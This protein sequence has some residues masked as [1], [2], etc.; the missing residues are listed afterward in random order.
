VSGATAER[1]R[2]ARRLDPDELAALEDE[3]DH[4]LT[5]LEDLEREHD[6]GDLDDA[7]YAT[8]KDDYTAR[9]AEVL[10]AIEE[11]REL[12]RA[13][14]AP[15][16]RGRT[17]LVVTAV[18]AFAVLAGVLVARGAG[19]RGAGTLTGNDGTLTEE[20]ADC[21]PLAFQDPARGVRCYDE[22]LRSSPDNPE[23]LTYRGWAL[24]RDGRI[25]EG[26]EA[27]D[28]AIE[29]A[30]DFADA[31]VFRAI[32]LAR[33]G[34][35]AARTGDA[36]SARR[37]FEAAAAELD[38]FHRNNPPQVAL[39]VLSQEL[40]EFKVF[41]GLLDRPTG[42]C[43]ARTL[44]ERRDD[45][46][47]DQAFYDRLGACLD[48]VLVAAPNDGDALVS[49][50]LT[51]LGPQTQ[52]LPAARDRVERA[53][54]ADPGDR[55]A[56]L[57]RASLAVAERRLE[58]AE[59]DLSELDG[60]RRPTASF[61]IGAPDVLRRAVEAARRSASTTTQPTADAGPPAPVT[62]R[63]PVSVSTVPGA[64]V[65]PNADGG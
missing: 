44:S 9:A 52:D 61:L 28:R 4:L 10:R 54:A 15:R 7:D 60:S 19:I 56:R 36:A 22:I 13:A 24:V 49:R 5:S 38:A 12:F 30:P 29:L 32:V 34:E 17:L 33:A 41:L 42:E 37:A 11:Q 47:L 20:L 59:A 27:I 53:L 16:D 51:F 64:P 25:R 65:I 21:Q 57:L 1:G 46:S 8:L 35:A 39:Q 3:R 58:D 6:A 23:A 50:A 48:G 14:A 62:T 45:L 26:T 43:W 31:R 55:N 40:L 2:S 63:P 18:L